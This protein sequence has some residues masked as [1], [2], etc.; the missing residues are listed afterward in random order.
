[1]TE[2]KIIR[3]KEELAVNAQINLDL[4]ME[5]QTRNDPNYMKKNSLQTSEIVENLLNDQ[6]NHKTPLEMMLNAEMIANGI[7]QVAAMEI[8]EEIKE[9]A[10]VKLDDSEA[11]KVIKNVVSGS[12]RDSLQTDQLYIEVKQGEP[13]N[14]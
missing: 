12:I 6:L 8:L 1:M 14:E 11:R 9:G 7:R 13:N 5:V 2:D 10:E 3:S 4:F